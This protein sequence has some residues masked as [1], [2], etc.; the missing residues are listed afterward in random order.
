MTAASLTTSI[1]AILIA[2]ALAWN[3]AG[4]K[5][6]TAA[7][8]KWWR[9]HGPRSPHQEGKGGDRSVKG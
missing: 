6:D 2:A 5:D 9:N 8:H 7:L 3:S 1:I 4:G